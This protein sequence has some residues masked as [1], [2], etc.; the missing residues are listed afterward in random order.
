ME[1]N[2]EFMITQYLDSL[3]NK[4]FKKDLVMLDLNGLYSVF[5]V[6][7]ELVVVINFDC[8][9]VDLLMEDVMS[10]IFTTTLMSGLDTHNKDEL[11][12]YILNHIT[13]SMQSAKNITSDV[14]STDLAVRHIRNIIDFTIS[15]VEK[16]ISRYID[17][18]LKLNTV[19]MDDKF[20][21]INDFKIDVKDNDL[22]AMCYVLV[23]ERKH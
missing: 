8:D 15:Y 22:T 19:G 10:H 12:A 1:A 16:S 21:T 5:N 17:P 7:K 20:Y 11:P 2:A 4:E 13:S 14:L 6:L 3:H 9:E 23:C 18:G